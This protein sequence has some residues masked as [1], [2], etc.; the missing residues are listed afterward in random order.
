[1]G[2]ELCLRRTRREKNVR[3]LTGK[4]R[5]FANFYPE[6]CN[7]FKS[8]KKA[9]YKGSD[10]TLRSI[11]S[12]N[13]TK[14]NIL[15]AI[16]EV[17]DRESMPDYE[18]LYRV[19]KMARGELPTRIDETRF[20]TMQHFDCFKPLETLGKTSGVLKTPVDFG[21]ETLKCLIFD[22]PIPS[23]ET[24]DTEKT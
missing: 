4:Q 21:E 22:A 17:M 14:P 16:K 13:L 11:G 20:G 3:R 7:G 8:A 1:M 5:K 10:A 15:A 2:L 12:E 18:I 24:E 9:G 19:T 6:E 23:V